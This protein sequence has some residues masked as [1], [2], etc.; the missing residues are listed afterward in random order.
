MADN[1]QQMRIR[2]DKWTVKQIAESYVNPNGTENISGDIY[3]PV[4]QREWAWK[5][6]RGE[7]KKQ[8]LIDSVMNGFPIPTCIV[9]KVNKSRYEVHDGRHRMETLQ[10][11][12]TDK[13]RWNSK[14]FSDLS[15]DEKA[16]FEYREI[17]ITI[18]LEATPVQL[19][20]AFIRLNSGSPLKDYDYFWAHRSR[21]FMQSVINFICNNDRLSRALGGLNLNTRGDLSNW[22]AVMAGLATKNGG[23]ITTSYLRV[24]TEVGL[25][26]IVDEHYV[27]AGIG[28]ICEL[29][30]E[31]N[32]KFPTSDKDK[33]SLKKVGK[34]IAYFLSDWIAYSNQTT[35]DK[36]VSVIGK[37]RSS[38]EDVREGMG[39][40]LTTSGAQ[41][42]TTT[43]IEKVL[44]QV[45]R[46]LDTGFNSYDSVM[47][48]SDNDD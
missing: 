21:P 2:E 36:W 16:R 37:L 26:T 32:R 30:E 31:A 9:N 45:N 19:A 10:L 27:T 41:N 42:L 17:P 7:T 14:L 43:K 38:E 35:H 8:K 20:D 44:G 18:M 13:F 29:L 28:A 3:V 47:S 48:Y 46:Y 25:D 40:A 6:L 15:S 39:L 5:H 34:I 4:S 22:A 11:Y 1:T 12:Y 23:N 33:R 24:S